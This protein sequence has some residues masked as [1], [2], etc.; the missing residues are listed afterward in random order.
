MHYPDHSRNTSL[1]DSL[2]LQMSDI[3][4]PRTRDIT[5]KKDQ[6]DNQL[7]SFKDTTFTNLEA[8]SRSIAKVEI[9]T[10]DQYDEFEQKFMTF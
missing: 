8:R 2:V 3:Q 6:S 10:K 5:I 4:R 7:I 1:R 9:E